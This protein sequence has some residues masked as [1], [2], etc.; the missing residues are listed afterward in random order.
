MLVGDQSASQPASQPAR[1][2]AFCSLTL[3]FVLVLSV[4]I[5]ALVEAGGRQVSRRRPGTVLQF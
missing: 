2:P 1:P 5:R 3:T 4:R